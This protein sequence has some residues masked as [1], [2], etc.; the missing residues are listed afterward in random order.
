MLFIKIRR[1]ISIILCVVYAISLTLLLSLGSNLSLQVMAQL[2]VMLREKNIV[3][4]TVDISSD[5]ELLAGKTYY[6]DFKAFGIYRGSPG[7][8]YISL[9]PEYLTVGENGKI[10]AST[11]FDGDVLDARVLVSSSYDENFQKIFTFRFVKFN[12]FIN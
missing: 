12:F 2:E 3:D 1:V 4:V 9:D 8:K 6:P 7:L 11:D 5:T 10:C